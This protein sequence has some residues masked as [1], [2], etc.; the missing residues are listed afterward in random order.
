MGECW[1]DVESKGG[2]QRKMGSSIKSKTI[3]NKKIFKTAMVKYS[4]LKHWKAPLLHSKL[5]LLSTKYIHKNNTH[6]NDK[7]FIFNILLQY[8]F[9]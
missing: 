2:E 9:K 1:R 7:L 3:K 4:W 6:W 8:P 5:V